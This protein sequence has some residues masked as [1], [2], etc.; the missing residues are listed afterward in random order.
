[1]FARQPS[2]IEALY[3]H[4]QSC[5]QEREVASKANCSP[6][7]SNGLLG[8]FSIECL[9]K[10]GLD[11][12]PVFLANAADAKWVV[13]AAT[14]AILE[15]AG[16]NEFLDVGL[17]DRVEGA[18]RPADLRT[19]HR[20]TPSRFSFPA[21]EFSGLSFVLVEPAFM[22]PRLNAPRILRNSSII[23]SRFS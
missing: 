4:R 22:F 8:E 13:F 3:F 18:P 15:T 6:L 19:S 23:A 5:A 2:I 11:Y 10:N 12:L 7:S 17:G 1:C 14:G 20:S 16:G 21:K 9:L